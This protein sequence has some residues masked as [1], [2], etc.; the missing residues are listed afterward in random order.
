MEEKVSKRPTPLGSFC[1]EKVF[2]IRIILERKV[3]NRSFFSG[4]GEHE[5][6]RIIGQ[7]KVSK[8]S[9]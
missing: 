5:I 8:K 9:S 7:G 4:N 2:T 3:S 6:F 1:K